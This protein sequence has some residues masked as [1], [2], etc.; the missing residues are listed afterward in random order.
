MSGFAD[1]KVKDKPE[2][3]QLFERGKTKTVSSA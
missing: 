2:I 1:K 3:V